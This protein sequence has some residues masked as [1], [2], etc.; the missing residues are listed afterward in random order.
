MLLNVENLIGSG[1]SGYRCQCSG[2]LNLLEANTWVI[3][4]LEPVESPLASRL[5]L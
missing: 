1:T 3:G 5:E 4:I 2:A